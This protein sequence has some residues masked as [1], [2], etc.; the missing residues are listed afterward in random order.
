[1]L[2]NLDLPALKLF[3]PLEIHVFGVIVACAIILGIYLGRR[4]AVK[5]G[6]DPKTCEGGMFWA[7]V[8]GFVFAHLVSAVFYFP[9]KIA[10]DPLYLLRFWDGISSFGGFIGGALGAWFYFHRAR[11]SF[12]DHA[13]AIFFGLVP[14]WVVG[15]LACTVIFD[16][17]GLPTTFFL[18]MA[19]AQ[20]VVRHNLGLYEMLAALVFTGLIYGLKDFRP[21]RGFHIALVMAL[22]APV[23]FLWDSLRI[24]DKTYLGLTPGQYLSIAML[25]V[26]LG[27][28]HVGLR[29]QAPR[30]T[31]DSA[32]RG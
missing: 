28:I 24:A 13:E 8:V 12:L 30:P 14:A 18:G 17:P 19:D 23:R 6:L 25:V 20:G 31:S 11:V 26:A 1:M 9:D 21:F 29:R 27:W 22:Y 15:R 4:R 3:G 32:G 7:V 5:V 2:P 16:H 10:A